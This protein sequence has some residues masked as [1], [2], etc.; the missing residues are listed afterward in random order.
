MT[1]VGLRGVVKMNKGVSP[2]MA[3]KK[4]LATH[5]FRQVPGDEQQIEYRRRGTDGDWAPLSFYENIE[6]A[7]EKFAEL[8]KER[9][10]L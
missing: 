5:E 9:Q 4:F 1:I 3:Y 8:T 2:E 7:N 10:S 6:L